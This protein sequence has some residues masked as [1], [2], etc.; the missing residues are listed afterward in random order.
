[1]KLWWQELFEMGNLYIGWNLHTY[2]WY[3][4]NTS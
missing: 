4:Q 1:M 3:F 2:K